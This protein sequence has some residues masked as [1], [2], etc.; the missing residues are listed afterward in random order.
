MRKCW[1]LWSNCGYV[2]VSV[3]KRIFFVFCMFLLLFHANKTSITF[4]LKLHIFWR[5]CI[6]DSPCFYQLSW[7]HSRVGNLFSLVKLLNAGICISGIRPASG[8][9]NLP[10]WTNSRFWS[11]S[12]Q[13]TVQYST[14]Q[15]STVQYSTV[16]YSTV[17]YST[18]QYSTV[19]Y[20]T[21]QY[22]TVQYSTVQYSTVQYSTVQYST[23]QYSTVQYSTVQYSTV[24]YSTVQYS[25][26]QYSTVQYRSLTCGGMLPCRVAYHFFPQRNLGVIVV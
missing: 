24:Q 19:Q 13:Y 22:S 12:A 6:T 26:V 23:V 21:V 18:V 15:Y 1:Y 20:S 9:V 3:Q 16:Q 11:I 14:V 17:Q 5:G 25:T 2:C 8:G 10:K 7:G 4:R